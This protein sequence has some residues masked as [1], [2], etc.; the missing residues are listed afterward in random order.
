MSQNRRRNANAVPVASMA[1]WILLCLIIGI[2]GLGYVWLKNDLHGSGKEISKLEEQL[3][4]LAMQNQAVRTRID[5]L[6]SRENLKLRYQSDK[7]TFAG[8]IEIEGESL[9]FLGRMNSP[10]VASRSDLRKVAVLEGSPQ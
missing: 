5:A 1:A 10:A 8:L 4:N 3:R 9:V 2:G 6:T 7:K